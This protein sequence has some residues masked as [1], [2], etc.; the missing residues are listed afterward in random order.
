M[1]GWGID[2]ILSG[3][4]LKIF[5]KEGFIRTLER[6]KNV[7][8]RN[9][10]DNAGCRDVVPMVGQDQ[11]GN[12]YYEDFHGDDSN[13][14]QLSTRWVEYSDRFEWWMTGRKLP[15]EWHGWLHRQYDDAPTPENTAF[16]NPVFKRRHRPNASGEP[17]HYV[18]LGHDLSPAKKTFRNYVKARV[19]HSWE[20]QDRPKR[21]D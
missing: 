1:V 7:R 11:H 10:M 20:P 13:D 17:H 3:K 18:P 2:S 21:Y 15:P 12:R 19:Y 4:F 9:I 5:R 14:S 16:H 6:G 8:Y